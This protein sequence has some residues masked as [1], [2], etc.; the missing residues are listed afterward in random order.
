M[1]NRRDRRIQT[2]LPVRVYGTDAEGKPFVRLAHTVDVSFSG[3]R[4]GGIHVPLKPGDMV[5]V[6]R[7]PDKARF[8]VVWVGKMGTRNAGELGLLSLEPQKRIWGFPVPAGGRDDYEPKAS[9]AERRS[10]FRFDC[11]LGFEIRTDPEAPPMLVRC[12]DISRG[13]CYLETWSP[14]PVGTSLYLTAKLPSGAVRGTGQVRTLD[15]AFGMG[16]A[17]TQVES[18]SEFETFLRQLSNSISRAASLEGVAGSGISPAPSQSE[19]LVPERESGFCSAAE[20]LDIRPAR[21]LLAEDSKFLRAA[22]ALY[23]RREG[24]HVTTADDG[25]QAL[26]LALSGHPDVIVL[27][28]LM[29]RLGGVGALKVLKDDPVTAHI[30]VIVLSGL[31]SSNESKLVASGAF[32]YLAKTQTGPEDLPQHVQR[33]LRSSPAQA[34]S[35]FVANNSSQPDHP[36]AR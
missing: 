3:A 12:T 29:P 31:P 27:D 21:V 8:R 9:I 19:P 10:H 17:F 25:Y 7:G 14:L 22:Y 1:G 35:P 13:G 24:F 18:N 23:L 4:V 30:P 16:I 36:M 15:P 6:Q 32:A 34:C 33:A 11:D 20:P 5:G 26:D 28:L 2:L